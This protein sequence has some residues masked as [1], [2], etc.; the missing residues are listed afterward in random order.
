[1]FLTIFTLTTLLAPAMQVGEEAIA[2]AGAEKESSAGEA[3][4]MEILEARCEFQ[5]GH[6]PVDQLSGLHGKFFATIYGEEGTVAAETEYW[7]GASPDRLLM[8]TFISAAGTRTTT[9][10]YQGESWFRD[11]LTGKVIIWSDK[12]EIYDV[13][14]ANL[15]EQ[16]RLTRLIMTGICAD[17]LQRKIAHPQVLRESV[18]MDPDEEEHTVTWIKGEAPGTLFPAISTGPPPAP[19]EEPPTI[20]VYVA[21]D[22][23]TGAG[24]EL[25][26]VNTES[27]EK[28]AYRLEFAFHDTTTS[29]LT[30][31]GMIKITT[32]S[33]QGSE[34]A[35]MK[36]GVQ[37]DI[38][39]QLIFGFS[40]DLPDTAYAAPRA[41]SSEDS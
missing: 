30:L 18:V 33:G 19:G 3:K 12:P 23:R 13:D 28:S 11:D 29:G 20:D 14:I 39:D 10:F 27:A 15:R 6:A 22:T 34:M 32:A 5:R 36:L 4:A 25:V 17:E 26:A 1:M 24:R 31:P 9:G 40:P 16:L 21:I 41:P 7:Y 8:S 38:D 2:T 35:L 37:D